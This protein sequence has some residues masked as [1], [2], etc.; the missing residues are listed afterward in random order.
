M[1]PGGPEGIPFKLGGCPG[2]PILGPSPGTPKGGPVGPPGAV[3]E[4]AGVGIVNDGAPA[5]G[6]RGKPSAAGSKAP[7]KT[8]LVLS[9]V[10]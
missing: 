8:V 9:K 10:K 4:A 1:C 7:D 2:R 6:G 5:P 3:G